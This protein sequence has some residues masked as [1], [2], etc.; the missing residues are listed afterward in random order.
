M[1]CHC[2]VLKVFKGCHCL[3]RSFPCCPSLLFNTPKWTSFVWF[4][5][6]WLS[7]GEVMFQ[8]EEHQGSI[9]VPSFFFYLPDREPEHCGRIWWPGWLIWPNFTEINNSVVSWALAW[10]N[11]H[12]WKHPLFFGKG[13]LIG[14][15]FAKALVAKEFPLI[16]D[17][18]LAYYASININ[19][20][21]QWN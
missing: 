10:R 2:P 19:Y 13:L 9:S 3:N 14:N 5:F 12:P 20:S 6:E 21:Q 1:Y 17:N 16:G 15:I 8:I 4:C 7:G 11:E 18:C